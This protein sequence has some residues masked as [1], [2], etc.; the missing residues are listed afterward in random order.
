MTSTS[1]S[2]LVSAA[3]D[4]CF[5]TV[6]Y[7]DWTYGIRYWPLCLLLPVCYPADLIGLG[8]PCLATVG[9]RQYIVKCEAIFKINSI[10][11]WLFMDITFIRLL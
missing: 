3:I 11:Q 5:Y 7:L 4:F 8:A 6:G 10:H 9:V 1:T 2:G